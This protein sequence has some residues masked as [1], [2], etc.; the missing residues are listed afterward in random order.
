VVPKRWSYV[1]VDTAV[2][3]LEKDRHNWAAV[4]ALQADFVEGIG[5]MRDSLLAQ[6][7]SDHDTTIITAD[8]WA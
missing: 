1:V 7:H 2:R 3:E 6:Q 4:G 8:G 5:R